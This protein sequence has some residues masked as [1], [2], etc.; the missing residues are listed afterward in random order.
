MRVIYQ[1]R[2]P[3]LVTEYD[4]VRYSLIKK[5]SKDIPIKVYDN[6][7][8]SGHVMAEDLV[9]DVESYEN[10]IKALKAEIADANE[11]GVA[12]KELMDTLDGYK[13]RELDLKKSTREQATAI[14]SL[15]SKIQKLEKELKDVKRKTNKTK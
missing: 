1:G 12:P 7:K 2:L 5:V 8:R 6:I 9:P 11:G 14:M 13:L 15:K 10:E 3:V 4:G